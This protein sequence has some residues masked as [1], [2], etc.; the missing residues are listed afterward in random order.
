MKRWVRGVVVQEEKPAVG[1]GDGAADRLPVGDKIGATLHLEKVGGIP[2][3]GDSAVPP[4]RLETV[5]E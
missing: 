4:T 1:E 5:T 3:R 2:E